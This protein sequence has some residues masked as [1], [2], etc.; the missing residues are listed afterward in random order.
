MKTLKEGWCVWY[1]K[2]IF[3]EV[4]SGGISECLSQYQ[5]L[6]ETENS[7]HVGIYNTNVIFDLG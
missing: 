7:S 3:K 1:F 5:L 2:E 4:F 6:P